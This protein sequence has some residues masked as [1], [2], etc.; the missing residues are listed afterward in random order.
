MAD[1]ETNVTKTHIHNAINRNESIIDAKDVIK[2]CERENLPG[3]LYVHMDF[4]SNSVGTVPDMRFPQIKISENRTWAFNEKG[5]TL[6]ENYLIGEGIK[7]D[8]KYP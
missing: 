2:I 5:I 6:W 1:R 8:Q 3:R 7:I 4:N